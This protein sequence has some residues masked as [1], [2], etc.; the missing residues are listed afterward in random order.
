MMIHMDTAN[1]IDMKFKALSNYVFTFHGTPAHA[2]SNP[3]EGAGTERGDAHDSR[4]RYDASDIEAGYSHSRIITEGG[5]ADNVI[6][7]KALP[8][9]PSA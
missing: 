4:L 3:W 8:N 9:T 7:D 2:S 5:E 6:P 1:K